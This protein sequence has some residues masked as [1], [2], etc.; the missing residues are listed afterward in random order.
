MCTGVIFSCSSPCMRPHASLAFLSFQLKDTKNYACS[1]GYCWFNRGIICYRLPPQLSFSEEKWWCLK[2]GTTLHSLISSG[3]H[4][5]DKLTAAV[6]Y[7]PSPQFSLLFRSTCLKKFV[8]FKGGGGG[9]GIWKQTYILTE[10]CPR[11]L[12]SH[13]WIFFRNLKCI[14]H[15]VAYNKWLIIVVNT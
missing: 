13:I 12:L 3:E 8:I 2:T 9:E 10:S 6:L 15:C 11:K 4:G 7:S 5:V 14:L 1:A